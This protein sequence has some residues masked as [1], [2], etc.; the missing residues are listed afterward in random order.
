MSIRDSK[1]PSNLISPS[2]L[3]T[4][5]SWVDDSP[6]KATTSSLTQSSVSHV[7]KHSLMDVKRNVRYPSLCHH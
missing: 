2:F 5:F 3:A 7:I 4:A 1:I 6:A